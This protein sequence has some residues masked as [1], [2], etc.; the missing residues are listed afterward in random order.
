MSLELVSVKFD[1]IVLSAK[2]DSWVRTWMIHRQ[3]RGTHFALTL[4]SLAPSQPVSE[5]IQATLLSCQALH[6]HVVISREA[7]VCLRHT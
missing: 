1:Y 3:G 4:V 2:S 6:I 7:Y 5:N